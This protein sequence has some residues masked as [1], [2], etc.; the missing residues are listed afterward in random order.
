VPAKDQTVGGLP[1]VQYL[2]KYSTE[3][4]FFLLFFQEGYFSVVLGE[5]EN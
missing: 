3:I 4:L 5:G 1:T 2:I